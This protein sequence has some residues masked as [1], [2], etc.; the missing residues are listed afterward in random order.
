MH[1]ILQR[2]LRRSVSWR[3]KQK[4]PK[5]YAAVLRVRSFI[6]K[7]VNIDCED[8][9]SEAQSSEYTGH[10]TQ[11]P[12]QVT[13][14]HPRKDLT[15]TSTGEN[16]TD[17][18][19]QDG[20][21]HKATVSSPNEQSC[22]SVGQCSKDAGQ[23]DIFH[24]LP[25]Q[26][27]LSSESL[28]VGEEQETC[29]IIQNYTAQDG[30]KSE[31]IVSPPTEFNKD[32]SLDAMAEAGSVKRK[33]QVEV[34]VHQPMTDWDEDSDSAALPTPPVLSEH[35]EVYSS[36][37]PSDA[38]KGRHLKMAEQLSLSDEIYEVESDAEQYMEVRT[39]SSMEQGID[40]L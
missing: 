8:G 29:H 22:N 1:V 40:L 5:H 12:V 7:A 16:V 18:I 21:E 19:S 15:I 23:C 33:L 26:T 27:N 38:G 2:M 3:E 11:V 31:V 34:E 9:S 35:R 20:C 13:S 32:L 37:R 6:L 36:G 30:G 10:R 25:V 24:A 14:S 39:I 17:T 4:D 28:D